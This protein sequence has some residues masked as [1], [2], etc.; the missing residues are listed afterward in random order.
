MAKYDES[1]LMKALNWAYDQ[2]VSNLPL[3]G[4]PIELANQYLRENDNNVEKAI[5][6]L[7]RWQMSKAA[8]TGFST[9]FGGFIVMPITIPA[10]ISACLVIQMRMAAAIAH[11]CGYDIHDDKVKLFCLAAICGDELV[12]VLKKLGIQATKRIAYHLIK[13]I[14][15][16]LIIA[17]NK[18]VGVRLVT[19]FGSNGFISL[20]K[21]IPI[22]GGIVGGAVD[23][24]FTYGVGEAAKL[25]FYS[26]EPGLA[27]N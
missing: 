23:S 7:I 21:A 11:M 6:S 3:I 20:S 9:G 22:L 24:V 25:I 16:H 18:A 1:T 10:D 15:S 5:D 19:K 4:S 26:D 8:A 2:S 13:S 27:L 12:T 14:P 17:I